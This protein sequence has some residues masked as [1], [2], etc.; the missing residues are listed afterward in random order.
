M[1]AE[2]ARQE[3]LAALS[4]AKEFMTEDMPDRALA[5]ATIGLGYA[6]LVGSLPEDVT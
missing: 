6:A 5:Q 3:A 4:K 1:T 2:E